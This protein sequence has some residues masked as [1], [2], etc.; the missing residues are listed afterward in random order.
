MPASPPRNRLV[1]FKLVVEF[2]MLVESKAAGADL[3]KRVDGPANQIVQVQ[4]RSTTFA[5]K[6]PVGRLDL[7]TEVAFLGRS[8][9]T[10]PV[11]LEEHLGDVENGTL[12]S[13]L[14]VLVG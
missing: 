1:E 10:V 2:L 7:F 13:E 9:Q 5:L 11:V 8:F 14:S 4:A 6:H 3:E 12:A